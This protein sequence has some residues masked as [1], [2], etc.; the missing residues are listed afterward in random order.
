MGEVTILESLSELE[1][2][3]GQNTSLVVITA[4]SD[5]PWVEALGGLARRGIR[6]NTVLIDRGSFGG[7]SNADALEHLTLVGV[8]TYPLARGDSIS[9]ALL[10]PVGG[11]SEGLRQAT[12]R[13]RLEQTKI[14]TPAE[15]ADSAGGDS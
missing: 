14:E 4:A 6:V 15:L 1:R 12:Y 8:S 9:N 2:D 11:S 10:N 7:D 3:L 5:G 13:T